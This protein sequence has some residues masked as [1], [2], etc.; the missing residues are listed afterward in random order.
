M[1]GLSAGLFAG[2]FLGDGFGC[3]GWIG[4]RGRTGVGGIGAEAVQEVPHQRFQFRDTAFQGGDTLVT[5]QASGT[6]HHF[7]EDILET[8]Q[9]QSES[10]ESDERLPLLYRFEDK[11]S[12]I[13][14]G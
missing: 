6:G 9:D 2:T 4:G 12:R 11:E 8:R 5:L 3:L 13:K 1:S 7:H 10:Q 14:T